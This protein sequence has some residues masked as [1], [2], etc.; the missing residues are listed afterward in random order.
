GGQ[1]TAARRG[2][3]RDRFVFFTHGSPARA[4]GRVDG[5]EE[6]SVTD[7]LAK[8][9][10]LPE[11]PPATW[12]L[13]NTGA[14]DGATNM[15]IDEAMLLAV[16]AGRARAALRCYGGQPPCLTLGQAQPVGAVDGARRAE[17]GGALVRRPTGGRAILHAAEVT[18]STIAPC[19]GEPR[20]QGDVP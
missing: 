18:Y 7:G 9:R 16:A 20:V 19:V 5:A 4:A 1:R 11:Y 13:L 12:R 3:T 6:V 14:A 15:A 10:G 2:R 17:R 8:P